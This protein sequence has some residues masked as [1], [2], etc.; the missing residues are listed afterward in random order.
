MSDIEAI[1][2]IWKTQ[3]GQGVRTVWSLPIQLEEVITK[4]KDIQTESHIFITNKKL[5]SYLHANMILFII[6]RQPVT[7]SV[8]VSSILTKVDLTILLSYKL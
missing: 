1:C 8:T 6:L 4:L 5:F 2:E 3:V 7:I